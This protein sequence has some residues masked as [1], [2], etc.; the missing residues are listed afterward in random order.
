MLSDS[1][2]WMSLTHWTSEHFQFCRNVKFLKINFYSHI[3]CGGSAKN[4]RSWLFCIDL[5]TKSIR[6]KKSLR[7]VARTCLFWYKIPIVWLLIGSNN[8]FNIESNETFAIYIIVYNSLMQT[9]KRL[10]F[11]I[12]ASMTKTSNYWCNKMM[13][14]WITKCSFK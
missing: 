11:W 4:F 3:L 13:L 6:N 12:E 9:Q 8:I 14:T 2:S 7:R 1:S 10:E 5:W